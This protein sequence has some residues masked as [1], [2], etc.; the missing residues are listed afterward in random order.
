MVLKMPLGWHHT[1]QEVCTKFL[2]GIQTQR[3]IWGWIS[4][5]I[6][7]LPCTQF[8]RNPV[9]MQKQP[10]SLL[11]AWEIW[12]PNSFVWLF[13]C[14]L[15]CLFTQALDLKTK[16]YDQKAMTTWRPMESPQLHC[17]KWP[18]SNLHPPT[19]HHVSHLSNADGSHQT[20]PRLATYWITSDLSRH[21]PTQASHTF[22]IK[23]IQGM[24]QSWQN[25]GGF[26]TMHWKPYFNFWSALKLSSSWTRWSLQVPF[27]WTVLFYSMLFF[28][29][30][31][32]FPRNAHQG[33]HTD[34]LGT[35]AGIPHASSAIQLPGTNLVVVLST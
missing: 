10:S 22:S 6:Q 4:L 11:R 23:A 19:I 27:G 12:D 13:L 26:R 1:I 30:S 8:W 24:P 16:P 3:V 7:L 25:L 21:N 15:F 31:P 33:R 34:T 18:I 14:L 17:A 5:R 28:L 2:L 9:T 29:V 32:P 20:T 35:A